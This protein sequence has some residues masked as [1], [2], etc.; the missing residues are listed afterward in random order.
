MSQHLSCTSSP[1]TVQYTAGAGHPLSESI[2]TSHYCGMPVLLCDNFNEWKI[3]VIAHLTGIADHICII[4]CCP[5]AAGIVTDPAHLFDTA[6]AAR[7]DASECEALGVIM[8]TALKL[9]S[10]LVLRPMSQCISSG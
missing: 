6:E 10:E 1:T 4:A 8:S 3:Q 2:A 9:H 7:W 5:D